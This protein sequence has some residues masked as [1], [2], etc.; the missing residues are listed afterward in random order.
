M[1]RNSMLPIV[2][3][4]LI[5]W[6]RQ[7]MGNMKKQGNFSMEDL[8]SAKQIIGMSFTLDGR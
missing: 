4:I 5:V 3:D 2:D 1:S 8:G 7:G 6:W